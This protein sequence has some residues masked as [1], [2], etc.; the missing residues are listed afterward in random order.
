MSRT[1][2]LGVRL[3][4]LVAIV[5]LLTSVGMVLATGTPRPVGPG[6]SLEPAVRAV[7]GNLTGP[8]VLATQGSGT[9]TVNATGGPAFASNG[10]KIGN[11]TY[12]ASATGA[13]TS[14]VT[15]SPDTANM[16]GNS[17]RQFTLA[18]GAVAEVL[19][20]TVLIASTNLNGSENES[21]NLTYAVTVV[22]P[23]AV[24][25]EI[26]N[27]PSATVLTFAITVELDGSTVGSVTIP[28]LTPGQTYNLTY[29]YATLGLASGEHT[30]TLLLPDL[31]GLVHFAN[32]QTSYSVTFYVEPGT[33]GDT[34][35]IV[36]GIVAFFAV[37]FIFATR[38][39]AR[40]RGALRR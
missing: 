33:S 5:V 36:V 16:T 37:L 31:H 23:Y 18:V 34:L 32:G 35:W 25:A 4:G 38:V 12:F 11:F 8:K 19:T 30:F 26:V 10:T 6:T 1:R 3:V 17:S 39:A 15:V 27:G 29:D 2:A 9:Y 22:V 14:G 13:N 20:I 24:S 21:L 40:R 7:T 28:S